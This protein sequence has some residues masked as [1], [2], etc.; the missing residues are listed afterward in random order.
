MKAPGDIE[1][2]NRPIEVKGNDARLY[3]DERSKPTSESLEEA[4][5]KPTV[6]AAGAPLEEPAAAPVQKAKRGSEPGLVNN[7]VASLQL[8]PTVPGNQEII[9]STVK[10]VIAAFKARGVNATDIVANVQNSR[11]PGVGFG[12]LSVEWWKA[13]FSAYQKTINMPIMV[14][15]FGKFFISSKAEDFVNWGCL[16]KSASNFGYMFGRQAGQSR[17]TYPKIFV[18]GHNK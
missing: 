8:D 2:N 3:A 15:G 10:E 4:P 13:G 7:V 12:I 1:V 6:P 17:E 11:D 9:N 16:P 14:I 18:P 5:K